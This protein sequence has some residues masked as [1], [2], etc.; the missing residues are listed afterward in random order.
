MTTA[1]TGLLELRG[2]GL[3]LLKSAFNAK[4]F[5][6]KLSWSMSTLQPIRRNSVLKCAMH[7]K[8]AKNL[9]TTPF[10]GGTSR[11]FKVIDVNKSKC[12][13][14]VL[15][16]ISSMSVPVCNRFHT[17]QG[18]NGKITSFKGVSLTFS[19]EGNPRAHRHEILS[20]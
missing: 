12:L 18:N 6:C 14:P 7:P 9:L 16:M 10:G 5:M 17:I 4:N 19:F 2:S 13:S 3:E 15:V 8:I 1:Y 11:S 20:Q